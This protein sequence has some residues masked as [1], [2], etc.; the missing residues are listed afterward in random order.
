MSNCKQAND[1]ENE[2]RTLEQKRENILFLFVSI[3]K[4]IV[5]DHFSLTILFNNK[6]LFLWVKEKL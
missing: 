1:I 6:K 2:R 3:L 4:N 5:F